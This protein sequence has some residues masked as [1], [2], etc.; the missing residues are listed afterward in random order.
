M[1]K[2]VEKSKKEEN[3]IV[4][5]MTLLIIMVLVFVLAI[6]YFNEILDSSLGVLILVAFIFLFG[7][8]FVITFL[9]ILKVLY[10]KIKSWNFTY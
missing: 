8:L 2:K 9:R 5:V 1:K 7:I 6:A 3:Q 10:R 4:G